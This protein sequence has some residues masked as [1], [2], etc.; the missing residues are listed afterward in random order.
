MVGE[1]GGLLLLHGTSLESPGWVLSAPW[2]SHFSKVSVSCVESEGHKSLASLY[3]S[4]TPSPGPGVLFILY[5]VCPV[6][7]YEL[8]VRQDRDE[9]RPT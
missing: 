3:P 2:V 1:G 8:Y 9:C 6:P 4:R 5:Q 7:A